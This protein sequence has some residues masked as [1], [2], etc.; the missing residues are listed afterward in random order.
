MTTPL[1]YFSYKKLLK[2]M[3]L[4]QKLSRSDY[5]FS[6]TQTTNMWTPVNIADFLPSIS[7]NLWLVLKFR[8]NSFGLT[9]FVLS[10]MGKFESIIHLAPTYLNYEIVSF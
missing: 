10:K 8:E 7:V 9:A 3:K 5:I 4:S 2:S 6:R 1:L